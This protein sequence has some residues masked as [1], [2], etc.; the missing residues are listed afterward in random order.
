MDD[1][2]DVLQRLVTMIFDI[3]MLIGAVC[4]FILLI[5]GIIKIFM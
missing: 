4:M 1:W 2:F 3:F 5:W